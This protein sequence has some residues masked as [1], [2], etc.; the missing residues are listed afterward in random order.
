MEAFSISVML[1]YKMK[2]PVTQTNPMKRMAIISCLSADHAS[3]ITRQTLPNVQ[4]IPTTLVNT[5]NRI[6]VER[7]S[8]PG[9]TDRSHLEN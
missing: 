4:R 8:I 2:M 5:G 9:K 7:C 6:F 1:G 3:N